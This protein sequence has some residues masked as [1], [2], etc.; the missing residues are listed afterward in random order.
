MK[1][2]RWEDH[3]NILKIYTPKEFSFTENLKYLTRSSNECMFHIIDNKI[4][5]AIP[6]ANKTP[7]VEISAETETILHVRFIG[8]T[9]PGGKSVRAEIAAYIQEWFDL[10]RDLRPFY[11]LAKTDRLLSGPVFD[12][13]GLR[14]IGIP[15][16]FEAIAW[17]ILGQQINLTYAYTLKRRLVESFGKYVEWDGIKYWIFPSPE[18]IAKLSVEDLAGL[19]MTTKKSEYLI[20]VAKLI[21][22]KELTK[23]MLLETG[24]LKKAEKMLVNIRGIGPWTANYVLMRCLRFPSAFPI[25]DVGLQNAIKLSLGLEKKPAKEEI[26][27]LS[28]TWTGWESYATFYLWRLLY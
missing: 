15:D 25:D 1:D 9:T 28:S 5:R 2:N 8:D 26:L 7:I 6:I 22:N 24:D 13:Y 10:E 18:E 11:M 23:E 16:L 19:K 12:F 4:Y 3:K 21:T 14:V 20:D 27:K 17:G